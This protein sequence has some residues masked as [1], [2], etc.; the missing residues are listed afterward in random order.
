MELAAVRSDTSF[1]AEVEEQ[2]KRDP[3]RRVMGGYRPWLI[4][5]FGDAPCA[6]RSLRIVPGA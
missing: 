4:E 6:D 2:R 5:S 3:D 1:T